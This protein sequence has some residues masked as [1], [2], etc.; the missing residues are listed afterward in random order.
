M[1]P[2]WF[3]LAPLLLISG[4]AFRP[5]AIGAEPAVADSRPTAA[6]GAVRSAAAAYRKALDE[7]DVDA[8]TAFWTPEADYVD[9]LGRVYKIHE[10][11][12]QAKKL[13]Q[14]GFH[15]ARH[16]AEDRDAN[17][18]LCHARG[19]HRGWHVRSHRAAG[20]PGAARTLHGRVGEA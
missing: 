16:R 20:R 4:E 2:V 10:G 8:V 6:E 12:D 13:S 3:A 17:D 14:E 7:K 19:G 11:L 9:Q 5:S 18:P 1:R 15:I